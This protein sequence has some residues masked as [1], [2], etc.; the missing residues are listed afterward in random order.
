[1]VS[2]IHQPALGTITTLR[3]IAQQFW[4]VAILSF[5]VALVAT[6]ICRRVAL[7]R[8][9]VDKPDNFLKPHERPIPYLGGVAIFLGWVTGL[10]VATTLGLNVRPSFM[11]GVGVAGL[12]IMVTG[13]FDDLRVMS[14]KTKLACNLVV[15]ALLLGLGLGDQLIRVATDF[16][17][18]EFAPGERWLELTYSIPVALLIIIGACN[19][20]NLIDGLDGLCSGVLGIISVGF[21]VLAVHL[22]LYSDVEMNNERI[23]LSLAMLGAAAGFLPFN[24]NPAKIF[25]GDAGSMLLGLNAAILILMF[26]EV[27]LV[28]WMIGALMVFGLPIADMVLTLARRWRNGRPLM[29]G[30]RSHFYDQLRDR[31]LTVRQVVAISYLLTLGF[32]VLGTSVIFLRTRYAILVYLLSIVG[33][34]ALVWKFD[35]VS[36]ERDRN[37]DRPDHDSTR[38]PAHA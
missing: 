10:A 18:V 8:G 33:V 6:P 4:P 9:I 27:R 15:A 17:R 32:V 26:G 34:A 16:M 14:P 22:R 13:L 36:I 19:A 5:G 24:S 35:M 23:V 1:L 28:R 11:L 37:G 12:A 31:G 25:M 3:E 7:A 30:D 21:F 38:S 29:Q 2:D 20:T